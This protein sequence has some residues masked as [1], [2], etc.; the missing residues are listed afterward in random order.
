[1]KRPARTCL[2]Q[3]L[4]HVKGSVPPLEEIKNTGLK[5]AAPEVKSEQADAG[6]TV[7][8]TEKVEHEAEDVL[9]QLAKNKDF[10]ASQGIQTFRT[11]RRTRT[12]RK[13]NFCVI[14]ASN[15]FWSKTWL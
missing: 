6:E 11:D 9:A 4:A 1:M 3:L 10:S 14:N 13:I 8:K 2:E 7:V 5:P 12:D 15:R